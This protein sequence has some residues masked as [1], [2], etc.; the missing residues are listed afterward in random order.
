LNTARKP[1]KNLDAHIRF[2]LPVDEMRALV[3]QADKEGVSL[4]VYLRRLI[5]EAQ[6]A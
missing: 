4:S 1:P 5:R 2:R 6:A 3:R